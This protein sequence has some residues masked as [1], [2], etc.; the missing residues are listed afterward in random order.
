MWKK[1]LQI[2]A[3]QAL[4]DIYHFIKRKIQEHGNNDRKKD[5]SK[6]S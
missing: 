6:K 2:L 3:I 5:N 4:P 1:I